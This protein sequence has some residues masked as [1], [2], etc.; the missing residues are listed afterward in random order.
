[1]KRSGINLFLKICVLSLVAAVSAMLLPQRTEADVMGEIAT[2]A[3]F[4]KGAASF[5]F[6]DGAPSHVSDAAPVF[7]K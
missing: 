1:M 6:D 3:G 7:D 2:W 4:R 5:T